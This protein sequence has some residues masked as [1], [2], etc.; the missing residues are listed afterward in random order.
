M[1]LQ[2]LVRLAEHGSAL[3][4]GT[5]LALLAIVSLD[6]ARGVWALF[7]VFAAGVVLPTIVAFTFPAWASHGRRTA[8]L[9][10]LLPVGLLL[11]LADSLVFPH[12]LD[13]GGAWGILALALTFAAICDETLR[14]GLVLHDVAERHPWVRRAAPVVA[15]IPF[16]ALWGIFAEQRKA[17]YDS[18]MELAA[19]LVT[20]LWENYP[21]WRQA[22]VTP[23]QLWAKYRPL[24][25]ESDG[26]CPDT[27]GPCEPFLR[28]L[29]DM[30][31]ELRNG[32][33]EV[34]LEND[35]GMPAVRV[36]PVEGKAIITKVERGSDADHAGIR[37][38]T[39]ILAVDGIPV[40]DAL[41]NVP[42]WRVSFTSARMRS[43]A[44]FAALLDGPSRHTVG[45]TIRGESDRTR[46]VRLERAPIR[47]EWE[48]EEVPSSELAASD[49]PSDQRKGIAYAHVE[50]F[51][52]EVV[53]QQFDTFLN[54]AIDSPGMILDLRENYGGMLD[55]A[56]HVLGR[57][58][59]EPL[60]IGQHCAPTG[61]D[62]EPCTEHR[63]EPRAPVYQGPIAVVID[64]NVYSAAELVAYSLCRSGRAR[65]FG[66]ATAGETDCVFRFDL[67]GA[68]ARVSWADFRPAFGPPLLGEGVEP[69]VNIERTLADVRLGRDPALDA[70]RAWLYE[71]TS[72]AT[73]GAALPHLAWRT[74][75]GAPHPAARASASQAANSNP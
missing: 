29:R 66:R 8:V 5:L 25:E 43:Y 22:P 75:T 28:T 55:H 41:R 37:A 68:V 4:F 34:L 72:R 70:A 18:R 40:R 54:S 10:I 7:G 27:T 50:G 63:I 11:P 52:E 60:V 46:E 31:A 24:L 58:L 36:E 32:H 51:E 39:E 47:Y 17:P 15:L 14:L 67:P 12:P 2:G 35:F 42:S 38:G 20:R 26:A 23:W 49:V 71:E 16:F 64:E 44:G 9:G 69:D 19:E 59:P 62:G 57:M 48:D 73:P 1:S 30:F 3:G 13:V 33:T 56:F 61:A 21:H 74:Q 65:C 53:T 45:V 6:D